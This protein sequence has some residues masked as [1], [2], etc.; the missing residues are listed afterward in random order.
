MREGRTGGGELVDLLVDEREDGGESIGDGD[1]GGIQPWIGRAHR[2]RQRLHARVGAGVAQAVHQHHRAV[3]G[4]GKTKNEG[5]DVQVDDR[6][7]DQE[8][9]TFIGKNPYAKQVC[10]K[11]NTKA[12]LYN[13]IFRSILIEINILSTMISDTS[14]KKCKKMAKTKSRGKKEP[15]FTKIHLAMA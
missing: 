6:E 14:R 15:K 11:A 10:I 9:S 3:G 1:G 2:R 12:T 4:A 8:F 5:G 7:F 13:M